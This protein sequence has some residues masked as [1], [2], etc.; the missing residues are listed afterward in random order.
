[1]SDFFDD[2]ISEV[3]EAPKT[4]TLGPS[5]IPQTPQVEKVFSVAEFSMVLKEILEGAFK[6]IKIKGEIQGLKRHSSGT[7]YFDLKENYGGKDYIL[8]CVLWKWTKIDVKLE[9]GLEVVIGGKITAYTGRSSYQITV[10]S[11]EVAGIGAL[12]K[13]IEERKQKLAA[14]GLFD[15]K[16]KKPIPLFPRTIGVVTSPTGAVIQDIIHRITDRCPT[17]IIVYPVAV[18]GEGADI[19]ITE[20]INNFNK[21]QGQNR[22]DVIIVARGGGS[23][24]DLMPFNEENVVRA[25]F[26]STIPVISAVG[27]ETDTTLID[28]VSDLRAPTPTGAAEKAVPVRSDLIRNIKEKENFLTNTIFRM[29]ETFGLKI[30]SLASAIKNPTQY[31]GDAIQ[32]LDDKSSKLDLLISS[33]LNSLSDK[34]NF[35]SKMLESYSFKNVLKRGYSIV[36]N[37]NETISSKDDLQ[38]LSTATVEF[39]N[40]KVD[41]FT[42]SQPQQKHKKNKKEAPQ[43][44]QGDLF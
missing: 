36:W 38:K 41:I 8:N 40:G 15:E 6:K 25:V 10:E 5:E 9:E 39:A 42:T 2:I 31:I 26:A 3:S 34:V 20:A 44:L 11:V 16:Y 37:G 32:R 35:A 21:I 1:M 28:Y 4:N 23:V 17:R 24:Q 43:N 33:K 14:E 27:H 7:Y 30:K 22:P 19:Q 12:L 13:L 29:F 18:Q